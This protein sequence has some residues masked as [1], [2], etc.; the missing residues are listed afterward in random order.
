MTFSIHFVFLNL[1]L[2]FI[3]VSLSVSVEYFDAKNNPDNYVRVN[4]DIKGLKKKFLCSG[5]ANA[6]IKFQVEER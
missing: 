2:L 6:E 3:L 1:L 4:V 5:A